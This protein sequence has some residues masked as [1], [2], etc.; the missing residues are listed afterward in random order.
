MAFLAA[1]TPAVSQEIH[2]AMET[3]AGFGDDPIQADL[4]CV[5]RDTARFL[6]I[7][8][9]QLSSEIGFIEGTNGY[10]SV[11]VDIAEEQYSNPNGSIGTVWLNHAG[12]PHE[13]VSTAVINISPAV[14]RDFKSY[15]EV[16]RGCP[17]S[18]VVAARP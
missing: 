12:L 8:Q 9:S 14:W 2:P 16:I 3:F 6:G 5:E 11:R 18:T 10:V 15:M 7:D 17:V 4:E 13:S 1:A